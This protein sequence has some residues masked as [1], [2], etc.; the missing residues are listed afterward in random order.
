M[1]LSVVR[2]ERRDTGI[3]GR[4]YLDGLLVGPTLERQAVAIPP[5]V[6][7]IRRHESPKFG[8]P[9]I[10]LYQREDG[11]SRG[12]ILIHEGSKPEHSEGCILLGKT[13]EEGARI[14]GGRPV[15]AWL[16]GVVLAALARGEEVVCV[17]HEIGGDVADGEVR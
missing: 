8:R 2:D 9:M 12:Y 1:I 6:W 16:E 10:H 15:V 11:L 4:L 17:V 7:R 14:S 5:G 3:E 13:D